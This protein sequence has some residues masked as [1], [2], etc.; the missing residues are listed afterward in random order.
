MQVCMSCQFNRR[1]FWDCFIS[2]CFLYR[3]SWYGFARSSMDS[4]IWLIVI[5]ICFKL[6]SIVL[7]ICRLIGFL[8]LILCVLL[9][10]L[11][12]SW[13]HILKH[14]TILIMMVFMLHLPVYILVNWKRRQPRMIWEGS[15]YN[16]HQ[17][18]QF[19]SKSIIVR[20]DDSN[21]WIDRR[22]GFIQ[23]NTVEEAVYVR[24]TAG[25]SDL[26]NGSVQYSKNNKKWQGI[27]LCGIQLLEWTAQ[28]NLKW[29][30]VII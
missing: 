8:L 4:C 12:I 2:Y 17:L 26:W 14:K 5:L 6:H 30:V 29:F 22:I 28:S 15:F 20:N 27:I 21:D 25:K 18:N 9:H 3:I 1:I 19:E 24:R 11:S 16:M 10:H 7:V 23:F 13:I